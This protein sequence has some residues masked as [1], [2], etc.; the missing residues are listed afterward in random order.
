MMK[1]KKVLENVARYALMV[2]LVLSFLGAVFV[3]F[4]NPESYF[5][6]KKLGGEKATIYLL[7][8]GIAGLVIA[9]LLF[10]KKSEGEIL[11]VLYFGYFFIETLITNLSL[12]F[13]FL[14]SPLPT[15]GLVISI[16]L[17]MVRK[18]K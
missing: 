9:Y 15:T 5:F 2:L 7:I 12:G 3:S 11:S 16:V 1:K 8:Q 10:K 17:L 18:M 14:T 13:G 4:I 6:G